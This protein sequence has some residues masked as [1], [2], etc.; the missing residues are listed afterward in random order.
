MVAQIAHLRGILRT[1]RL[2]HIY[3]N[4][5]ADA[6]K[7]FDRKARYGSEIHS[8]KS[9]S[10]EEQEQSTMMD[11]DPGQTMQIEGR[12]IIQLNPNK[13]ITDR[14]FVNYDISSK[15][16]ITKTI[17]KESRPSRNQNLFFNHL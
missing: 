11:I 2:Y 15:R 12:K 16:S 6:K 5:M 9:I 4:K 7:E 10:E 1:P 13:K 8:M 17:S 3:A 14:T